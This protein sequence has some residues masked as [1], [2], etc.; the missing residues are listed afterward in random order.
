V[1]ARVYLSGAFGRLS[2]QANGAGLAQLL[3]DGPARRK[4]AELEE[5]V[6]SQFF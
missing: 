6:D 5:Y 2:I 4:T 1:V 3:R